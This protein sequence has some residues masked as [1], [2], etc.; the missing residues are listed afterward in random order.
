MQLLQPKATRPPD[1]SSLKLREN[2]VKVAPDASQRFIHPSALGPKNC[3]STGF[4]M[5]FTRER[6]KMN[7]LKQ[8]N[9]ALQETTLSSWQWPPGQMVHQ[10]MSILEFV[11]F[12]EIKYTI[13]PL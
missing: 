9:N 6:K 5:T 3:R 8:D 1:A 11:F 4:I 7:R 2:R 10:D 13:V 12:P